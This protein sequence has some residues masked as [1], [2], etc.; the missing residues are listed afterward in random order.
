MPEP[1]LEVMDLAAGYG[2][3]P[4][5]R[6]VS[7]RLDAGQ[8][9]GLIGPNGHGKTTLMRV[10]SGLLPAWS[11]EVLLK[12]EA[13]TR[14]PPRSIV[15]RGLV[16]VPQGNALFPEMSVLENLM[17]GA[18]A[19]RARTRAKETLEEVFALFPRLAERRRQ[20]CRSLSGGERQMVAV[21][22]GLMTRPEIL[23]LD[24]PTLGLSPKLKGELRDAIG[25]IARAG[26]PIVLVEQDVE[27]MLTLSDR[28]YLVNQGQ[29]AAEFSA[30][31]EL[32]HDRIMEMYFGLH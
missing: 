21:G 23:M 1:L 12:G 7:L 30:G 10:I 28:F 13:V 14:S 27:F 18:Y 11:G 20:A 25:A 6:G 17:L 16:Q 19:R 29:V 31:Q 32:D 3:T 15:E 26:T 4:V 2:R 24:E 9:I 22:V 5:L 8:C